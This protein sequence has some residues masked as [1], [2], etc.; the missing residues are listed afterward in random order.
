MASLSLEQPGSVAQAHD[1][2]VTVTKMAELTPRAPRRWLTA[3]AETSNSTADPLATSQMPGCRTQ[4]GR[5]VHRGV[6]AHCD[7]A[8]ELPIVAQF[9]FPQSDASFPMRKPRPSG[10]RQ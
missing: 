6:P 9:L 4:Q 10:G 8:H 7:K 1:I 3:S 2:G 5:P